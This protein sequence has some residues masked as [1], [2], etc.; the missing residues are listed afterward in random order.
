MKAEVAD[1]V[2]RTGKKNCIWGVHADTWRGDSF[3]G[4]DVNMAV[5]LKCLLKK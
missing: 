1:F 2:A 4:L 3:E 5:M